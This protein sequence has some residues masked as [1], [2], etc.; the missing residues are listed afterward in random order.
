MGMEQHDHGEPSSPEDEARIAIEALA[1]GDLGHAIFHAG[2]ALASDPTNAEWLALLDKVIEKADDALSFVEGKND[3]LNASVRAYLFAR[4]GE[5][6]N[7][8][9]LI[10][11]VARARPDVG[12]LG[13]AEAW[14]KKPGALGPLG[15]E[16]V[17]SDLVGPLVGFLS[18]LPAPV[19]EDNPARKDLK[20]ALAI[21]DIVRELHPK[22][23]LANVATALGLRRSARYEDAIRAAEAA[24]ASDGGWRAH[25][26]VACAKRDA[27]DLEGAV[28]AFEKASEVDPT[29]V[30]ALL[31]IGDIRLDQ[32]QTN[33]ALAA[34]DQALLRQAD[35]PWA[36][37]SATYLRALSTKDDRHCADLVAQAVQDPDGRAMSLLEKLE[38]GPFVSYLPAHADATANMIRTMQRDVEGGKADA[39]NGKLTCAVTALE[40]PSVRTAFR[41]QKAAYGLDGAVEFTVTEIQT[42]DPRELLAPDG[43]K[44]YTYDGTEPK[45]LV[46]E[47]SDAAVR[48]AVID[49]AMVHYHRDVWRALAERAAKTLGDAKSDALVA[50]MVHPPPVPEGWPRAVAWIQRIQTAAAYMLSF[51]APDTLRRIAVGQLDWTIEAAIVALAAAARSEPARAE[52]T[53]KTFALL[54]ETMPRPGFCPYE[55]ALVACFPW[56]PNIDDERRKALAERASELLE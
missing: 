1:E 25:V 51:L 18:S 39:W 6:A 43:L 26:A 30:S 11:A 55:L 23:P 32:G 27:K 36:K 8:L 45:P 34:Y 2:G 24:V 52:A 54:D 7:A 38:T 12:Y 15:A 37:A 17:E 31:D 28:A 20:S 35:Q 53:A 50:I 40:P 3:F 42:P 13:W 48:T 41:L 22:M 5:L 44:L 4:K 10:V 49:L 46:A 56:L 29:D 21:L 33:Y 16:I 47:D 14:V 19:P 9:S